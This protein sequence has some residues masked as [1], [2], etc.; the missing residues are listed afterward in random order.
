MTENVENFNG[1][2]FD[3]MCILK[4]DTLARSDAKNVTPYIAHGENV[5]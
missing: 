1:L 2:K 4:Q 3:T 5:I